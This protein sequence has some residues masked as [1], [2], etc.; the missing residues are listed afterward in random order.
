LSL[1]EILGA[2]VIHLKREVESEREDGP[3][4]GLAVYAC[5][6][7]RAVRYEVNIVEFSHPSGMVCEKWRCEILKL[8]SKY[9]DKH[10]C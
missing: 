7:V 4:L 6:R 8:L 1:D 5:S 10:V 2:R 3:C 9:S